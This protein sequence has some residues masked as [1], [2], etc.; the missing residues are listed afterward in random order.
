MIALSSDHDG[1]IHY[2]LARAYTSL[3]ETKKAKQEFAISTTLNREAHDRLE[4]QTEKLGQVE[5]SFED[6]E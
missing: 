2:K 1:S 6:P 3:R 4:K 5:K